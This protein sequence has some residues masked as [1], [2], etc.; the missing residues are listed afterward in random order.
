MTA[1][2]IPRSQP[3]QLALNGCMLGPRDLV[4][5]AAKLILGTCGHEHGGT[6][7]TPGAA[8]EEEERRTPHHAGLSLSLCLS[9]SL[10]NIHSP[11]DMIHPSSTPTLTLLL[12][13]TAIHRSSRPAALP[14]SQ[15]PTARALVPSSSSRQR[16]H[17]PVAA[18]PWPIV[19]VPPKNEVE[20]SP[21]P[22]L[23]AAGPL[24]LPASRY[25]ERTAASTSQKGSCKGH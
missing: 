23:S 9:A 3:M 1:T 18:A 6:P 4:L 7:C 19:V 25:G 20:R 14:T 16:T 17:R 13:S 24:L 15:L 8:T 5:I 2:S 22:S 21:A 12:A 11:D 10:S